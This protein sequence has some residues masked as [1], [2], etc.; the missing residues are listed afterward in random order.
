[1]KKQVLSSIL[2]V[3]LFIGLFPSLVHGQVM[4]SDRYSVEKKAVQIQPFV[5]ETPKPKIQTVKPFAQG[6]NFTIETTTPEPFSFSTSQN[7]LDFGVLQATNPVIRKLTL[8]LNSMKGYQLI[9]AA[10][11]PLRI[12]SNE[13][14]PDTTCDNGS[15]SDI[16]EALWTN[17]LTYGFGYHTDSMEPATFRQFPNMLQNEVPATLISASYANNREFNV[18]YKINISNTQTT[19][20][21]TN[22]IF[23]IATPDF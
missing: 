2:V 8:S 1:M 12:D 5:T 10:D 16:T 15:C 19:G 23:Y 7:A 4:T 14:I 3:Y 13:T 18:T 17:T 6:E 22:T 20:A 21:Y 9:T 11:H